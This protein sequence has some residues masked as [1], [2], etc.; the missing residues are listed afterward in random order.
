MSSG[1]LGDARLAVRTLIR[2]PGFSSIALLTFALGI[3]GNAAVFAVYS[4][5]LL[6][7]LPYPGADRIVMVW[8]DNRRQ[9]IKEDITSYPNYVDWK[10]QSSSFAH[11][12]AFTPSSFTLTGAGD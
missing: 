3:G 11:M 4:G 2:T 10:T 1:F 12:S 9:A 7:P 8:M 6:R 5:V